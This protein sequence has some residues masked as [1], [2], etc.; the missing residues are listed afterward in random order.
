ME[1]VEHVPLITC[2]VGVRLI[3]YHSFIPVCSLIS[4]FEHEQIF[5]DFFDVDVSFN[6]AHPNTHPATTAATNIFIF[7]SPLNSQRSR[8]SKLKIG[9]SLG[10]NSAMVAPC[11]QRLWFSVDFEQCGFTSHAA[12]LRRGIYANTQG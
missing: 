5:P 7:M 3:I 4:V 9:C 10:R 2:V 1:S 11:S 12:G 6:A 8:E